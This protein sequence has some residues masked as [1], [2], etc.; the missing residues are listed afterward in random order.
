VTLI[1]IKIRHFAYK[2]KRE[3][4]MKICVN[5]TKK[6][7][8]K[9][10]FAIVLMLILSLSALIAILPTASAHT[11]QWSITTYCFVSARS[12]TIGVGQPQYVIA[13]IQDPP[14]TADGNYGDRWAFTFEI[15]KP[16]GSKQ[17]LGPQNSDN[18]GSAY[19]L[20]TPTDVGKYTVIAKFQEHTI[21]GTPIYPGKTIDN[22]SGAAYVNDTYKASTSDPLTFTVQADPIPTWPESP[23]PTEYWT[24]PINMASRNWYILAGN[25][26]SG[27]G[28]T[29]G[30]TE[31]FAY[32]PGPE[33]AHVMWSKPYWAGGI[34]DSRLETIGFQ[35][36]HYGG[37]VLSPPIIIDGKFY[38]TTQTTA[39]AKGGYTCVDLFS[40]ETLAV[41]PDTTLSYA[42]IYNYESPNQHG[43]FPYLWVT[44]GVTLPSGSSTRSGT[45]T[46]AM[47][48]AYTGNLITIIANVSSSGTA[49]YGK[50]GS[51]LRYSIAT[52]AGT[53][54]LRVWNSSAMESMLLGGSGTNMWQWRPQNSPVHNG[55][56]AWSLNVTV[57][58]PVT[59]NILAVREDEYVIGGTTNGY[60]N[61]NGVVDNVMWALSLKPGEEGKL[62]WNYSYTP[63][64]AA[65]VPGQGVN[66]YRGMRYES[67]SPEDG[68]FIYREQLTRRYWGFDLA[69]GRQL[70]ESQPESSQMQF[71][72]LSTAVNTKIYDGKFFSYG[73]G[74]EVYA[75]NITTG[76]P[77]WTYTAEGIGFE[78]PYGNFPV[79]IA[80]I[81]DGKLYLTTS[82]HS[83]TS[84]LFRG[85]YI[86]CIYA[87]NGTELWKVLHWSDGTPGVS[88]SGVYIADGFIVSLNFYD[89]KLYCY[90]KGPSQT[91]VTAPDV[92]VELG[93][94]V[95]IQGRITDI[96][97]GT[98]QNEQAARFP[99]GVPAVSDESMEAW[100]E[101][102]YGQQIKPANVEGVMVHLAAID[103]NGNFQDMG[104]TTS[105]MKGD[106]AFAWTPP[107]PGVYRVSATFDGSKSYFGSEA[108]TAFVVS[109]K[110]SPAP[111]LTSTPTQQTAQPTQTTNPTTSPDQ[112]TSVSPSEAVQPPT[113]ATPTATYVAVAALIVIIVA[114]AAALALRKRK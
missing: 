31:K 104:T 42:S 92:D 25:W 23:L 58:P 21:T 38:Y 70:W 73:Y 44:S 3:R 86:R 50:D 69:T 79:G 112:T 27:A 64:R 97:A 87:D 43:G 71:Y 15:T 54:Y 30:P 10:A 28:N 105:D 51:I 111:A 94:P 106:F 9:S 33:S 74:G 89:N 37:L 19:V 100:M 77:I 113:S 60:N 62:L 22:I 98:T 18:V 99:N 6:L 46:W 55:D 96:A 90:G 41:N 63:P 72:G 65:A 4:N 101:Y 40:G 81:A 91:T 7:H 66:T 26:L 88:G 48:D 24:R 1:R 12:F 85:S 13:W 39:H 20:Y 110:T 32:G 108:G 76:E 56:T 45:S 2:L 84:P 102:V 93:K 35:T 47:L 67:M 75:Y 36:A 82:E 83:P 52:S 8:N 78:S 95:L 5:Q 109:E 53:Q 16:D 59:G 114:A 68:V 107:V 49:V 80:C 29:N 103:P 14:P 17:T 11:P 34:M 57:S 61:D